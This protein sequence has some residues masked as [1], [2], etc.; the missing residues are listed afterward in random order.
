MDGKQNELNLIEILQKHIQDDKE[1]WSRHDNQHL[2]EFET[3]QNK[4]DNILEHV[5]KCYVEYAI[6]QKEKTSFLSF[7]KRLSMVESEVLKL[8]KN[9]P[10]S[11]GNLKD[12]IKDSSEIKNSKIDLIYNY[13]NDEI[14]RKSAELDKVKSEE[15]EK[16]KNIAKTIGKRIL[17][18]TPLII[19]FIGSVYTVFSF[20]VK[21]VDTRFS[22][23]E[24]YLKKCE[25]GYDN[26]YK[27]LEIEKKEFEIKNN[28][29]KVK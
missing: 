12:Y 9:L 25:E 13:V 21:S 4:I 10:E 26:R 15:R 5:K 20:L 17:N 23:Y 11:I 29:G 8:N 3:T 18:Y 14:K 2:I 1:K 27:K 28:K 19:L 24:K 6:F 7:T 16:Y 22:V